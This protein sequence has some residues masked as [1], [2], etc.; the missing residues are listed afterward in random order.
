MRAGAPAES[1]R[2]MERLQEITI[3]NIGVEIALQEIVKVIEMTRFENR[4]LFVTGE[5]VAEL[6]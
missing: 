5:C 1:G 2:G 6:F 3:G 4:R